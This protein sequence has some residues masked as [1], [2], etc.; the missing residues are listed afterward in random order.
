MLA[1]QYSGH[2][3]GVHSHTHNATATPAQ[4]VQSPTLRTHQE[5]VNSKCDFVCYNFKQARSPSSNI[6]AAPLVYF[7]FLG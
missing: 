7:V 6:G 3:T 5:E 4:T 1:L 2:V